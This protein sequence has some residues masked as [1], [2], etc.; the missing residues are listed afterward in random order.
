VR[1]GRFGKLLRRGRVERD[2]ENER[3]RKAPGKGEKDLE[4]T[5]R[6]RRKQKRGA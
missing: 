3:V 6:K 4:M 2:V 5:D 1:G